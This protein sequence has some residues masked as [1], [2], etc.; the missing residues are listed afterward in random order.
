MG[1]SSQYHVHHDRPRRRGGDEFTEQ[2][3][4]GAQ[5]VLDR[6][7]AVDEKLAGIVE[8]VVRFGVL[9]DAIVIEI[10]VENRRDA[11]F[12]RFADA[13][14]IAVGIERNRDRPGRTARDGEECERLL[15]RGIGNRQIVE[16]RRRKFADLASR[17]KICELIFP[18][19]EPG[20]R[21]CAAG[22]E[23]HS[24]DERRIEKSGTVI[25]LKLHVASP[26]DF[27]WIGLTVEVLV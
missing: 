22:I 26:S 24:L 21:E 3:E 25:D 16:R 11:F 9:L 4:F 15:R 1:C 14:R 19:H 23:M 17:G 7:Y 20:K 18:R 2:S 10:E 13:V 6:R 12:G 8:V 27:L 5:N